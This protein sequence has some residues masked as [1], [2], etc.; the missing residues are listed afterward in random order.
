MVICLG[1]LETKLV[2]SSFRITR[3]PR[4]TETIGDRYF[5]RDLDQIDVKTI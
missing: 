3:M 1:E 5:V 2:K 4:V